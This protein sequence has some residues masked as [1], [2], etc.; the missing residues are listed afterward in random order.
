MATSS[1][2]GT[3]WTLLVTWPTVSRAP[4][5]TEISKDIFVRGAVDV[6]TD[7]SM[8]SDAPRSK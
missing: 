8:G 7:V 4:S 2:F 1:G 6:F 5:F 3:P